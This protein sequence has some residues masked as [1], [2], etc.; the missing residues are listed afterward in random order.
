MFEKSTRVRSLE[1]TE[2]LDIIFGPT[3]GQLHWDTVRALVLVSR[4]SE[5]RS[6]LVCWGTL[7]S[8]IMSTVWLTRLVTFPLL[9]SKFSRGSPYFCVLTLDIGRGL[10]RLSHLIWRLIPFPWPGIVHLNLLI[11]FRSCHSFDFRVQLALHNFV[12]TLPRHSM[13]RDR[14]RGCWKCCNGLSNV[15]F[16]CMML[17]ECYRTW[18]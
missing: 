8:I 3:K 4:K 12:Q 7:R 9:L 13:D 14:L 18:Q 17:D 10:Y 6:T 11:L 15:N 16:T 2:A 5:C 1:K